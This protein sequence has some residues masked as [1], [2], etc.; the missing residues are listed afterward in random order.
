MLTFKQ[1]AEEVLLWEKVGGQ[2]PGKLELVKTPVEVAYDYL[3]RLFHKYQ[4]KSLDSAIPDFAKNYRMAQGRA[5]RRGITLR[6][7]MPVIS[8]TQVKEFKRRLEQG[9][10]DLS[11]PYA[12]ETNPRNPFPEGLSGERA[13]KFVEAGIRDND[14]T[15]DPVK[16]QEMKVPARTLHPIQKQIYFDKALGETAKAGIANTRKFLSGS[17]MIQSADHHIIDGHHRW[18][19]A[20]I[21][22]PDGIRMPS[23]RIMLPIKTLLPLAKAYGD[24]LGNKRNQ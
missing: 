20:I 23:A 16:V 10:I 1:Y 14:K 13:R 22:D 21:V 2:A 8:D 6:R 7:N 17:F 24:C 18:L 5:K 4:K 12:K 19:S 3:D 15:D 9:Y 11:R